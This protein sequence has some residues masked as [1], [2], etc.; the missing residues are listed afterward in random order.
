MDQCESK[1]LRKSWWVSGKTWFMETRH[2]QDRKICLP[3]HPQHCKPAWFTRVGASKIIAFTASNSLAMWKPGCHTFA[4]GFLRTGASSISSIA[5]PNAK[6]SYNPGIQIGGSRKRC[7]IGISHVHTQHLTILIFVFFI[8]FAILFFTILG[9]RMDAPSWRSDRSAFKI[10]ALVRSSDGQWKTMLNL[11]LKPTIIIWHRTARG[12]HLKAF[13]FWEITLHTL[14][15][16]TA[17]LSS[18]SPSY[19]PKMLVA[20]LFFILFLLILVCLVC[21]F[22]FHILTARGAIERLCKEC[23]TAKIIKAIKWILSCLDFRTKFKI[24]ATSESVILYFCF[25][26]LFSGVFSKVFR[27]SISRQSASDQNGNQIESASNAG[28]QKGRK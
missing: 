23:A 6:W 1:G 16:I 8:V 26:K 7:H 24:N 22:F 18:C 10:L 9:T 11:E 14:Y 17:E 21:L 5:L 15:P 19:L 13:W 27:P 25:L 12:I 3:C 20:H 2:L 4:A 28:I